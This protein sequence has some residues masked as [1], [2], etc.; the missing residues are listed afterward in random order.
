MRRFTGGY[1]GEGYRSWNNQITLWQFARLRAVRCR[2]WGGCT[3]PGVAMCQCVWVV[4]VL[5]WLVMYGEIVIHIV[6][7]GGLLCL[8]CVQL[9]TV[10]QLCICPLDGGELHVTYCAFGLQA[11]SAV[12]L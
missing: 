5:R 1:P 9:D 2:W 10:L 3:F 11:W 4:A 12:T 6:V 7:V 8:R